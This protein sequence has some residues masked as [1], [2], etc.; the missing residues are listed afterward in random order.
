[1][2]H[3]WQMLFGAGLV[4]TAEDFGL[5]GERP[6]HPELLDWLAMEFMESGW[7]IQHLITLI[8][9]SAT[10]RQDSAISAASLARDPENRWLARGPRFRLPSWMLRDSALRAS[11]L[12]NPAV[13]GRR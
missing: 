13:G 11:G 4:R 8:V 2:N 7:D 3:L 1:M 9:T 10:Y 6:T 12:L 5:Q